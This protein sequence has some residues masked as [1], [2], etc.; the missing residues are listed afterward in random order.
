MPLETGQVFAGYTIVRLVGTGGMGEVYLAQHPRLP[1][2]DALKVLPASFSA[3]DEYRHRFSREAD[4]AAALWHPHIVGVHDRGEYD[5]RLWISMDFVDGHDAARLLV[6]R[7]PN[8]MPAA[9]VIEIVTAVADALDYAHQR[10]L[11]HRDVKPANILITGPDRARRRILLAD[12]GI[13]RHAE[14]NTGLTSSN[15]AVGS[16][17]YSAP[18]Q[19]MG[20]AIDGRSDQYSLAATAYRLFTGS[21]P[22]PHSN[23]AVIISHHLN[24]PPPRLGDTRPELRAFDAAMTR[25]LAKDPAAR[26]PTCHE[27]AAALAE[28]ANAP[29]H[30]PATPR[31]PVGPPPGVSYPG[32]PIT[33]PPPQAQAGGQGPP[34]VL[35]SPWMPSGATHPGAPHGPAPGRPP[36]RRRRGLVVAGALLG[37]ILLVAGVVTAVALGGSDDAGGPAPTTTT[38]TSARGPAGVSRPTATSARPDRSAY[39]IADYIR[40]NRIV[41]VPIRRE[42]PDAPVVT[43]PIPPGWSDAGPRAPSWAY[44]AMVFDGLPD[45]VDPPTVIS[46]MSKLSGNVDPARILQYAP[47]ELST[48][49]AAHT[50]APRPGRLAGFDSVQVDGSYE[51]DG[52]RRSTWQKTVVIPVPDALFVLQINGDA[53]A[54]GTQLITDAGVVIDQQTVI[55]P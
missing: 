27:F 14:D 1:R 43:V 47:N 7:Y 10:Q 34:P 22:F 36:R 11:L 37:V 16:M 4:L 19:L 30:A 53:P 44:S 52:R 21:P 41:E 51:R 18:E 20:H 15:I 5:G 48:L 49:P 40:D 3:D 42:T 2:Q 55:A 23:P 6:D 12:F 46:L 8:G 17:S 13:A 45:N 28:A 31:S 25:A 35:V 38:S 33:A 24:T 50:G 9:D 29:T 39:T 26:F 54:T 32:P